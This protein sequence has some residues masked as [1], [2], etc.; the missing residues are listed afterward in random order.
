MNFFL[1]LAGLLFLPPFISSI[2][3][4]SLQL[5]KNECCAG[6]NRGHCSTFYYFP[7]CFTTSQIRIGHITNFP[8]FWYENGN[9]HGDL[10]IDHDVISMVMQ[11]LGI[12]KVKYVGYTTFEEMYK[13][14][15]NK[16]VD[17]LITNL[18]KKSW[19]CQLLQL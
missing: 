5:P 18:W 16:D 10:G 7:R 1:K 14:L 12:D 15:E 17:V 13:A 9:Q 4:N 2:N 6:C 3:K 11:K 19:T 8:P